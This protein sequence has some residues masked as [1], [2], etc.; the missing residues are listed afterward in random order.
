MKR[1]LF[2]VELVRAVACVRA[3]TAAREREFCHRF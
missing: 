3:A 2:V 1:T